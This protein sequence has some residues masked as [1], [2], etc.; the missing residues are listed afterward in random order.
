MFGWFKSK[1]DAIRTARE[2]Y[3]SIVSAA[4][5]ECFYASWGVADEPPQRLEMLMLH[6][7]AVLDR[8][9]VEGDIGRPLALAL[10]DCFVTDIDDN[11]REMGIGDLTVPKKVK[12]AAA[13]LYDRHRDFRAA[14]AAGDTAALTAAI[15][16]AFSAPPESATAQRL[17]AYFDRLVQQL[18][19][20]TSD[21]VLS[22]RA[23][24][25]AP[26]TTRA[27]AHHD[28]GR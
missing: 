8:L 9:A 12:K 15:A 24:F 25:P 2:F 19:A 1:S 23:T 10:T 22:G 27:V 3:G 21:A 14:A 4:R 17:T 11:M 16:R 26:E 7:V 18:G 28:I 20:E 13:A 6:L 5:Q